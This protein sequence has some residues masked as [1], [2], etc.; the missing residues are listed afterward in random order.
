[1]P[2]RAVQKMPLQAQGY[3]RRTL[4]GKGR[5]HGLVRTGTAKKPRS[6][7]GAFMTTIWRSDMNQVSFILLITYCK[8]LFLKIESQR[9]ELI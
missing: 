6:V 7:E 5:T 1:M 8:L 2:L 3:Q 9:N 4:K